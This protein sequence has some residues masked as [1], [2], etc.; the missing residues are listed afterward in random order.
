M[1]V[2]FNRRTFPDYITEAVKKVSKIHARLPA[3]GILVFL[4]GQNE[5]SGVCKKLEAKYGAKALAV[6]KDRR[7]VLSAR[8]DDGVTPEEKTQRIGASLGKVL[9][10][11][12]FAFAVH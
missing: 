7:Q 10:E 9:S 12:I 11:K 2:H 5:I 3:G 8:G 1:T 6:K 4:T